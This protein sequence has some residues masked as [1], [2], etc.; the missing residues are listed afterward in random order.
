MMAMIN[1]HEQLGLDPAG[2]LF[3][4]ENNDTRL[5]SNDAKF[6]QIIHTSAAGE[7]SD[8]GHVDFYANGL[9]QPGCEDKDTQSISKS[10][11]ISKIA[12]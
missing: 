1:N 5:S 8:I 11:S 9:I 3:D 4:C 2:P 6:V 7:R 10:F 12:Y